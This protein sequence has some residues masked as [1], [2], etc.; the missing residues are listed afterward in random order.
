MQNVIERQRSIVCLSLIS[1]GVSIVVAGYFCYPAPLHADESEKVLFSFERDEV[2]KIQS[3]KTAVAKFN[4]DG[5]FIFFPPQPMVCVQEKASHGKYSCRVVERV[6]LYKGRPTDPDEPLIGMFRLPFHR[7]WELHA[8]EPQANL[9]LPQLLNT[10]GWFSWIL[11]KDWSGYDLLR[12]DVCVETAEQVR[13]LMM[14]VE[15]DVV[16]P[17]V[18]VSYEAPPG[19]K[20]VTLE[21]DLVQ[22]VKERKL[23]LKNMAHIWIRVVMKDLEESGRRM[24]KLLR[25]PNG[26]DELEKLKFRAYV[27]NIRLAKRGSAC[28]YP[29]LRGWRSVYTAKLPR[30]YA[31]EEHMLKDV[32]PEPVKIPKE[33][34]PVR[35][36]GVYG[37]NL[38]RRPVVVPAPREMPAEEKVE[39]VKVPDKVR[40]LPEAP[41][42]DMIVKGC[43]DRNPRNAE[44]Y[45]SVRLSGVSAVDME[46]IVIGFYIFSMGSLRGGP[47]AEVPLGRWCSA[48]IGTVD[49]KT[50]GGVDG[51]EWPTVMGG[52]I[53]KVPPRLVDVGGAIGG[54]WQFGCGGLGGAGAS[55]YPV[56][57]MFFVRTVLTGVGYRKSAKY[58]VSGDPRHCHNV[59][60]GDVV[61]DAS[62]RIWGCWAGVDR[63]A[64]GRFVR[65]NDSKSTWVYYSDDG[66]MT[67]QSWRGAGLNGSIPFLGDRQ[68]RIVPY[69]GHIAVFGT[70]GWTTF[71]GKEWAKVQSAGVGSLLSD[72]VS[73]GDFIFVSDATG[74]VRVYDG[75]EWK[76]FTIPGRK[77]AR[78]QIGIC[79]WKKVIFVETDETGR[80]LLLWQKKGEEWSGPAELITEKKPIVQVRV[81]RYAPEKFIVAAYMCTT[82]EQLPEPPEGEKTFGPYGFNNYPPQGVQHEPWIKTICIPI[83]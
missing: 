60:S 58:F 49:G 10:G 39:V 4:E 48:A 6:E 70:K 8:K 83:D 71:D 35:E 17:P 12:V 40:V 67:W 82:A 73:C 16:E 44:I 56:D 32:F 66:G 62:G 47:T 74:P 13:N 27:D 38:M 14:E 45:N 3:G 59:G 63:F 34:P 76:P 54:V 1:I 30:S 5:S 23:N 25:D 36:Q 29:V 46:H 69:R 81:Q 9:L 52:H 50:W 79:G 51:N 80:K 77:G 20:W 72:V 41:I 43:L 33:L 24:H 19:G 11:P 26:K 28:A 7:L 21:M 65:I 55:D 57:M 75:K 15:D 61:M 42:R 53:S 22:A 37:V 18:S 68:V 31:V 64:S 78:G 2:E